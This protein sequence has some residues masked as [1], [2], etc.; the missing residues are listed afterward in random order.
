MAVDGFVRQVPHMINLRSD[1]R[2]L[3]ISDT[4]LNLLNFDDLVTT[5]GRLND[6][7]RIVEKALKLEILMVECYTRTNLSWMELANLSLTYQ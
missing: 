6:A 1:S 5:K 4:E 3:Q 2:S 7:L